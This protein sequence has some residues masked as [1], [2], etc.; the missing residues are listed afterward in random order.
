[1][2]GRQDV[3]WFWDLKTEK[4]EFLNIAVCATIRMWII[5]GSQTYFF[6]VRSNLPDFASSIETISKLTFI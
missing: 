1:M 6:T 5:A 4:Y 3:N 2:Y